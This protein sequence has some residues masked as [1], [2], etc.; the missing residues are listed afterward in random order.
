MKLLNYL[1]YFLK[2][3]LDYR[4]ILVLSFIHVTDI[5]YSYDI[6]LHTL[7]SLLRIKVLIFLPKFI[8]LIHDLNTMFLLWICESVTEFISPIDYT[9]SQL[10]WFANSIRDWGF[11][12]GFL[13]TGSLIS[14]IKLLIVLIW[15]ISVE[16]GMIENLCYNFLSA[17]LENI[18]FQLQ[19]QSGKSSWGGYDKFLITT[20]FKYIK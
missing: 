9:N 15:W 18:D 4:D 20:L 17:S 7:F 14:D 12:F 2:I 3:L 13:N 5:N 1:K 11:L 16:F 19:I 6:L 10:L 8:S